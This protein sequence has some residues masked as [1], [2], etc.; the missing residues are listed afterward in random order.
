MVETIEN[1]DYDYVDYIELRLD[2]IKNLSS[3]IA[4]EIIE[5]VKEITSIPIILTN[6]T[7]N[8]GGLNVL[9]EEERVK[10]LVDNASL[11][12]ITDIEYFT[13]EKLRQEVI[14]ASNKTIISYHNFEK[15]PSFGYLDELVKESFKV[16]DIP[17]IALKPNTLEDTYTV[18]KLLMENKGIIAISMDTLGSYTRIIAPVM[19]APVTYASITEESAPGQFDVKTT[20]DMIKK[21]KFH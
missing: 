20:V 14:N 8:E 19:G 11:V 7:E 15:T 17:K 18:L 3:K 5:D 13:D 12:E 16:G 1:L 10:I 6:R 9:T 4:R 2:S 21:L